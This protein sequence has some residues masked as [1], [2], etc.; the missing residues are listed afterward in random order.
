VAVRDETWCPEESLQLW[1]HRSLHAAGV[2]IGA[3]LVF[4]AE[5]E[6]DHEAVL[7]G[8]REWGWQGHEA[9]LLHPAAAA[10]MFDELMAALPPLSPLGVPAAVTVTA[11]RVGGPRADGRNDRAAAEVRPGLVT[12]VTVPAARSR[13]RRTSDIGFG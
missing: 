6:A 4:S 13:P 10:E 2:P 5:A 1:E 12:G 7:D 9:G 11:G 8:A 3:R